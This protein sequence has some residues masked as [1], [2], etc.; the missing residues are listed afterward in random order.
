MLNRIARKVLKR[1]SKVLARK[2]RP[3]PRRIEILFYRPPKRILYRIWKPKSCIP[4]SISMLMKMRITRWSNLISVGSTYLK[5]SILWK[6]LKRYSIRWERCLSCSC[7]FLPCQMQRWRMEHHLAKYHLALRPSRQSTRVTLC[8][9][10]SR[11]TSKAYASFRSSWCTSDYMEVVPAFRSLSG[12]H[13]WK[14]WPLRCT[15]T[16]WSTRHKWKRRFKMWLKP[17]WS[18]ITR[19]ITLTRVVRLKLKLLSKIPRCGQIR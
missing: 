8:R 4:S 13:A 15:R 11:S 6:A 3:T 17:N 7:H 14:S 19:K 12:P 1:I 16:P 10:W 5:A 2:L 18:A 9:I